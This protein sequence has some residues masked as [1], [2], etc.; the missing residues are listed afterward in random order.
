LEL[1]GGEGGF[2][3]GLHLAGFDVTVVDDQ[4]RPNRAPGV[5]WV[6]GDATTYPL[7]GFDLITGGPPCRDHT[8]LRNV[9]G[10]VGTGWMLKHTL[11]RFREFSSRT[12]VPWI[13]E[14]VSGAKGVMGDSLKLCGSMFGLIDDGWTLRRHRHFASNR[15]LM[16]PGPCRCHGRKIIGVYGDITPDDRVC[17]GRRA[18]RPNGDMRAG[19]DRARR[20]MGM[21][22]ASPEGLA[23]GIPPAYAEYLG[24]QI[25]SQMAAHA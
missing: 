18:T 16:A 8:T 20:L 19:A 21:P 7:E 25:M 2:A 10:T 11:D 13:V 6:T 15:L 14:N 24:E 3:Y 17:S 12:G 5:R 23:L 4:D 9:A 22:W 1:F